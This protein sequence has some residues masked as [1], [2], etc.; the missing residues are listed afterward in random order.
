MDVAPRR[1]RQVPQAGAGTGS[2]GRW[3]PKLTRQVQ[4][5]GGLRSHIASSF[6]GCSVGS[7]PPCGWVTVMDT[8]GAL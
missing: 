3:E 8:I 2:A 7:V 1:S 6:G 5:A 4:Q